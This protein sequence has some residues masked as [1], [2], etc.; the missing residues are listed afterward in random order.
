MIGIDFDSVVG[1]AKVMLPFSECFDDCHQFFVVN[2]IIELFFG[3][4]LGIES[5]WVCFPIVVSLCELTAHG[6]V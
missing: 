4:F 1:S 3:E 2:L 6:E 5:Y